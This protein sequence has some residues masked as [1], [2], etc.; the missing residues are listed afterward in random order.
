MIKHNHSATLQGKRC[1]TL[2]SMA[3]RGFVLAHEGETTA[4][5]RDESFGLA[6]CQ[7]V[8]E[9]AQ[10]VGLGIVQDNSGHVD[11]NRDLAT[12]RLKLEEITVEHPT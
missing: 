3:N 1:Q 5:I 8:L 10:V 4:A 6:Q 12:A 7:L 11:E 2:L 9:E